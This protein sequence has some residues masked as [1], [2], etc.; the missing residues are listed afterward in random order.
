MG[1]LIAVMLCWQTLA[2]AEH[3][4]AELI[5]EGVALRRTGDDEGA[6][7]RFQQAYELDHGARALGQ[8][9]LAE[10]AL[11]RW[12]QAH[13]DLTHALEATTDPWIA[14][15]AP[16]L[17]RA[18][19]EVEE[20]VGKLD[21]RGGSA[22]AEVSIDGV[23][24]GKLPLPE[25]LI[26]PIGIVTVRLSGAGLVAVQRSAQIRAHQV[27][28][29]SFDPLAA[30][31]APAE[32]EAVPVP[33]AVAPARETAA[34]PSHAP[35]PADDRGPSAARRSAKWIAWGAAAASLGVGVFGYVRQSGATSDFNDN[36]AVDAGG[37]VAPLTGKS[38]STDQCNSW[39]SRRDSGFAMELGGFI[40]F[41]VAAATGAVLWL[42]EPPPGPVQAALRACV[43]DVRPG[44]AGVGCAWRF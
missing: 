26:L 38:V 41:G 9:G 27:S 18:L 39:R 29:E 19:A 23:V 31:S 15:N 36:C 37:T 12:V 30:A 6:L 8:I 11:G 34:A 14:K 21:I 20:H 42:T 24:R 25:P 13:G 17:R 40:G 22:D 7:R 32:A 16:A 2:H 3:G 33:Q 1:C 5:Q 28:R 43:P 44:V 10:Q 4:A 35:S